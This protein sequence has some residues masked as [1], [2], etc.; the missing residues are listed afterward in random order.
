MLRA[1]IIGCGGITERRHAPVLTS[2]VGHVELAALADVSEAR[3]A[4]IGDKYSVS[5]AHRYTDY[6]AML[7]NES[8]DLV[9]VCTPHHLHRPQAIAALQAG[10]H[11]LM[12]KPIAT[13]VE[14][15][16]H[17]IEAAD[18]AGKKLTI[19]H[20]Q[21]FRPLHQAV[22]KHIS[23]GDIG[24]V[25][26]VRTEGI[27]THHVV[28]RGEGQH[29]RTSVTSGGGGPLIDNGYHQIYCALEY[30][31]SPAVRVYARV[32]RFV[33][34]IDTEDL[35]MLFI[36]HNSGATISLQVGWCATTGSI[37]VEEIYGKN[38][39]I[40]LGNPYPISV[41]QTGAE[42]WSEIKV[43]E[44][45]PDEVGFPALAEAFITSIRTRWPCTR[46]TGGFTGCSGHRPR[47]L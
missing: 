29:W 30:V 28:G 11:V 10:S 2:F 43:A 16:N 27:S 15:A 36:E 37:R 26:L 20:N 22:M 40:R 32:G 47:R 25:F 19:S 21:L 18:Q 14:E 46:T 33:R 38:G 24:D 6:E 42:T 12:E 23:Q 39:Q 5:S 8:L 34:D 35:A 31:Q 3:L 1:G 17:I 13:S 7:K 4:L 41:W 45:R 9:H 44:E